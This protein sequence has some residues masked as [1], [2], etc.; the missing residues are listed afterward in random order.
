MSVK[1]VLYGFLGCGGLAAL[2]II[3]TQVSGRK[4]KIRDILH[5]ITQKASMEKIDVLE[6]EQSGIE[7]KIRAKEKVAKESKKRIERIQEK[8]AEDIEKILKENKISKIHRRI[9]TQWED[10]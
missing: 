2:G 9:D 8:A 7:I 5:K 3:W 1:S 10:L 4:G 6:K